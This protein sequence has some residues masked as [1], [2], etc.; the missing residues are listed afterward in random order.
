MAIMWAV[1]HKKVPNVLSRCHTS[2]SLQSDSNQTHVITS[3]TILICIICYED[4]IIA[5]FP[6]S[7]GPPSITVR[8]C[9]SSSNPVRAQ[10]SNDRLKMT[11]AGSGR[12]QNGGGR[13]RPHQTC[14]ELESTD[15]FVHRP[16]L[17]N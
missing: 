1:L 12:L 5:K 8:V 17:V 11:A 16:F 7:S 15:N 10:N 6:F 2:P 4:I 9:Q 14:G 3:I 13:T